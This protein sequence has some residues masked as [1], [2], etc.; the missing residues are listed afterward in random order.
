MEKKQTAMQALVELLKVK[1]IYKECMPYILEII[2][3]VYLPLEKS[4]ILKAQSYAISH[5]DM[6]NNKGE[7]DCEKYYNETYGKLSSDISS[8]SVEK[9]E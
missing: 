4:Q 5:A 8:T 9:I 1:D 3:E 7:F 2:D 6:T